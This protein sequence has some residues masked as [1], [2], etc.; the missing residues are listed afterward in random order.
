MNGLTIGIDLGTTNS[1][2]CIKKLTA[3]AIPNAEGDMLTP[4]CVTA[5]P[6][7]DHT[8]FEIIVGQASKNILKQYPEQ[9]VTSVKRLIGRDFDEPEVQSI[10]LE[11]KVAYPIITDPSEPSSIRIPFAGEDRTPENISGFIL[12]KIIHDVETTL[13]NKVE[14]VVVTV[15]AYFSDRQKFA[16]RAAC[17]H[18]GINLLRLLPEPAAAALSFGIQEAGIDEAQTI[19]LFDL[20]GGTFD[21]SVLSFAGGH[22]MEITKGGDMWL[23]GDNIDQLIMNHVF[24]CAE[25]EAQCS[26][27]P[28]LLERL[29]K[30]EKASFLVELKE[31]AEAAKIELS[32]QPSATVEMF[33][34]LKDE[35][36]QCIDIDVTITRETFDGLLEPMVQKISE[37]SMQLLHEIRFEPELIDNVLL[38]GGTS[39][40]PAIQEALKR[41]FGENK[42]MLHPRPML[43]VAEGAALMAANM[44]SRPHQEDETASFQ[45]LHTASHDYYLQLAGGKKHVLLKRNAPLPAKIEQK[46]TFSH[47]E[48]QLARLR[49]FN[50]AEGILD[51]VGE[52]WFH[53]EQKRFDSEPKK[54]TEIVLQF[55]VD[56]DNIITMKAW[57]LKNEHDCVESHIA[58]GGLS[59]KLFQDLEKTLSSVVADSQDLNT[60][61]D[62]I[63]LSRHVV[64]TILSASDPRTGETNLALKHKAQRQIET[65][66][67]FPEK[68]LQPF[69]HYRFAK[70]AQKEAEPYIDETL[71]AQLKTILERYQDALTALDNVDVFVEIE[72][73]LD[74]LYEEHPVLMDLAR[75]S[76]AADAIDKFDKKTAQQLREQ[77]KTV[78]KLQI[79]PD[80]NTDL[81]DHARDIMYDMIYDNLTFSSRPSGRFDRDV[82][83]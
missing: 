27:I 4:S 30:A 81:I 25:K 17:N 79:Y 82:Q 28:E 26:P 66:K 39:L 51:T 46:L 22:F 76:H 32:T 18:A 29:S 56:E 72:N 35:S 63:Q 11:N 80:E 19:M 60:E 75:A 67:A 5:V 55:A 43:A 57:N 69:S 70:L 10:L 3:T 1:V 44:I 65:L 13:Q 62:A 2:A 42:V 68:D 54:P 52:I 45:M 41:L 59:A 24:E 83:L 77:A 47:H 20:G 36:N 58:R 15:P 73:E 9:T 37:L 48:Q 74:E 7:H 50:E 21:I 16:T 8:S 38:V 12:S 40:I 71:S 33:G 49:V 64:S 6:Q 78:A 14:H 34:V 31:K 23:G 53:R 61:L